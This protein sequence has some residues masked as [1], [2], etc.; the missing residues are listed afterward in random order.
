MLSNFTKNKT[1][2]FDSYFCFDAKLLKYLSSN[3]RPL[4]EYMEHVTLDDVNSKGESH[5]TISLQIAHVES[6]TKISIL[7]VDKRQTKD[8]DEEKEKC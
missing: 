8:V 2:S 7:D 1:S 4:F 3:V 5:T 6:I